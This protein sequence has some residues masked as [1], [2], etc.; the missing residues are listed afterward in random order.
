VIKRNQRRI[1]DTNPQVRFELLT[2]TEIRILKLISHQK[3][4]KEIAE[5]LFVSRRT[6]D[7]HRYHICQKL[8]IKGINSLLK[9]AI[10]PKEELTF[11]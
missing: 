7:N 1:L 11:L 8:E 6:V 9:F 4:T 2:Q 3:T 10:E 5:E